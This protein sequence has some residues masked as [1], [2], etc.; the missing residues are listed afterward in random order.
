MRGPRGT[1][2]RTQP[3]TPPA[4]LMGQSVEASPTTRTGLGRLATGPVTGIVT[5]AMVA[6]VAIA[7]A[8]PAAATPHADIAVTSAAAEQG[9]PKPTKPVNDDYAG[10]SDAAKVALEKAGKAQPALDTEPVEDV[11]ARTANS[12]TTVDPETG[13]R[14]TE[15]SPDAVNYRDSEGDWQSVDTTLV[16]A[17][18]SQEG[19]SN[20]AAGYDVDL[21]QDLTDPVKLADANN[22]QAWV[23]LQLTPIAVADDQVPAASAPAPAASAV[24]MLTA[25][26]AQS[27]PSDTEAPDVAPVVGEVEGSAV[28]YPDVLPGT[29]VALEAQG[30]GV[31]ETI[32]LASPA[33]AAALG[34]GALTYTVKTG[35]G[36]KLVETDDVVNVLNAKGAVVF[37]VPA[38][39]M[40]DA[41]GA[42]SEDIDVVLAPG[43][44]AGETAMTV[45][46]NTAWLSDPSRAW[47]V[48]IDPTIQ[49]P[50]SI[51]GCAISSAA[52]TTT[53]C[54]SGSQIPLSWNSTGGAAQRGLLRFPT[55]LDVIPADA[56]IAQAKLRVK[57][58][59][60]SGGASTSVDVK[61]LT[62][63]FA[64]GATWNTR[65]GSTPWTTAGGDR[66]AAIA[67]ANVNTAT[68]GDVSFDVA[69]V[70]Q[71]WAEGSTANY[72]GFELEKTAA[73][74]GGAPVR[75]TKPDDASLL[76]EWDPRA[77]DRK[78]NEAITEELSDA[79]SVSVNPA[80]G[81]AMVTTQQLNIAGNGLDVNLSHTSNSLGT[82]PLGTNGARWRNSLS[83]V[84]LVAYAG[85]IMYTDASA[86]KW[87][88]Y[89]ALDGSWIRPGG[90][91]A[92]LIQNGDGTFTLTDRQ[93]RVAQTF[94][95][96]GTTSSP[97]YG[98]AKVVDAN[99]NQITFTYDASARLA[100]NNRLILRKVTDTRGR[101]LNITNYGYWDAW[102][103]DV[104]GREP[105]TTITNNRLV[106]ETNSGGGTTSYEY[107]GADRVTAITVP[108]G[109]RTELTYDTTGRVLTLKRLNGTS[110]PTW[111]FSY[112]AFN[113]TTGQALTK[114]TVTDPNGHASEY[115]SDGRGR[116]ATTVNALGKKVLDTTFTA[117]DDSA[118]TTGATPGTSGGSTTQTTTNTFDSSG[119]S[120]AVATWNLTATR[121]PTGVGITNTYGTGV[122]R[123]D[124]VTSTDARGTQTT[125]TYDGSGNPTS[126]STGGITTKQLYQGNTDPDYGGTVNCG[127]TVNNVITAT[128]AGVLC[129]TRDGAYVK[130]ATAA[131]TTA[132]R[133]AYRYNA[134]GE[135]TTKLPGTPSAQQQQTY[136]YDA[137]SRVTQT[138]DGRGQTTFYGYDSM[139]RLTYTLYQDGRVASHYFGA[140]SGNGWLQA[141]DEYPANSNTANRSTTYANDT[142][143]RLR[144]TATP[145]G[146]TNLGY[147]ATGNLI[148]YSDAGGTVNYGYNDADQLTS[149]TL[150][151]GSCTG[152]TLTAPGA[153]S[154]NCVLFGVDDDGRRTSTRYPGGQTLTTT[155]DDTGRLKQVIG[156]T[157]AGGTSMGTATERL[158][159]AYAYTDPT[160]P[161]SSTNPTKD[162]GLVTAVTDALAGAKTTYSHDSL[163]RLTVASTAPTAGG[164][165]TRYEG[166]CYDGAG[167]RTKYLNTAATNCSTGTAA[168]TFTYNGGNELTDAIGVTPTGAPLTGAGFSYDANGNQ[169]SSKSQT[170]LSTTY[171]AQEQASSFTPAGGSSIAQGYATGEGGNG[172][173]ITSGTGTTATTFVAS[174]LSP[175]PAWAKTAGTSTWTV[176]DPDGTLIAVRIGVTPTSATDYYPFS[177]NVESVR[178]MVKADGTMTNSY[179]YSAYGTTLSATE[180]SGVSQPYRYGG[181]YT[182]E[183]TGLIKLG[184]RFYDPNQSRF[185][186]MDPSGQDPHYTYAGLAPETYS[187]PS[188]LKTDRCGGQNFTRITPEYVFAR[189]CYVHDV[190]YSRS[191]KISR[192]NCDQVFYANMMVD[193]RAAYKGARAVFLPACWSMARAYFQ[194]VRTGAFFFYKGSGNK[195]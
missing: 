10:L 74:S 36:L 150:P 16:P 110:N 120:P 83:G 173:R 81:N 147:D 103:T 100:Y 191:S 60:V 97:S 108:E 142:L 151:G 135:L 78:A 34:G 132:H 158:N 17:Q 179:S 50:A 62:S 113:R 152:Q 1:S 128:K 188:G 48:V 31:K 178:A 181:G 130:G 172:E 85:S 4:A 140:E 69:D 61:E 70:V 141:I 91:D 54:G 154:T 187:D 24:R 8:L 139:D 11:T 39:F 126:I 58:V 144:A 192:L 2:R 109:Q 52:P 96:I 163:D 56:Q 3:S 155:L 118:T 121:E 90:L 186:Q 136:R 80:T 53:S 161:T 125:Y 143:G 124:V 47:P 30:S 138:T 66:T 185:T 157:I 49:F 134:K 182:D 38:P 167:N 162:T 88:F 5:G 195:F 165:V 149:L 42:H 95:D 180:A 177:D 23:S 57:V 116:V 22:P 183:A 51:L 93:S 153:A 33:A 89:K 170:S 131:A 123:Y 129:E 98:L 28:T 105:S 27:T 72:T 6:G 122:L 171:G 114:T 160:A 107:D 73:A 168:A 9:R 35:P 15:V 111:T 12:T 127:P 37:T 64:A 71:R 137:L 77:G 46:P 7:L 166:F 102:V 184:A 18:G 106:S 146:T 13:T 176:R 43:A 82:A 175:A 65:N 189:S 32:T 68:G 67:R 159:L 169:T 87:T 45:T 194:G 117:N 29:D 174:P 133:E 40:D 94:R 99:G 145:E 55:L 104:T 26:A 148:Q 119:A 25:P 79:T 21:P 112:G 115:T 14:L 59:A 20:A 41:T 75:L 190:C 76:V 92:D 156:T 84:S 86:A 101:D 63:P 44:A 164:A 19:W 193:C